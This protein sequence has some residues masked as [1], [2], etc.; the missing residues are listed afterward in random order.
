MTQLLAIS[1]KPETVE[2][3]NRQQLIERI[4]NLSSHQRVLVVGGHKRFSKGFDDVERHPR[5]D[6]WRKDDLRKISV[7]GKSIEGRVALVLLVKSVPHSIADAMDHKVENTNIHMI[8][9]P[10]R[11]S[12]IMRALKV[13]LIQ[14]KSPLNVPMRLSHGDTP[15]PL[16]EIG[17]QLS[18]GS[19][20]LNGKPSDRFRHNLA[21]PA[22][23]V[24]LA[25]EDE[26]IAF[27]DKLAKPTTTTNGKKPEP[28]KSP[29]DELSEHFA[30]S[31]NGMKAKFDAFVEENKK[32]VAGLQK[33]LREWKQR[34]RHLEKE[35][36]K[37][38]ASYSK[39]L[40][41]YNTLKAALRRMGSE[42]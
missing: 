19:L 18:P 24:V 11:E 22:S 21:T 30:S 10:F 3:I 31:F 32:Q 9:Y 4:S 8:R 16:K 42:E 14:G 36:E 23:D 7:K 28:T 37:D 17:F 27:A 35:K 38:D 29:G 12:V 20:M 2:E 41:K 40:T 33:N 34:C 39:L 1:Q 5:I 26:I 25:Q 15:Q 13:H 6:F